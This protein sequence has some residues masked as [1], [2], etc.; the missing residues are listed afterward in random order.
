MTTIINTPPTTNVTHE[1]A[2]SGLGVLL[3]VIIGIIAI[4]LFFVYA[5]PQARINTTP[6]TNN[7]DFNVTVPTPAPIAPITNTN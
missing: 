3:G 7:V 1:N 4:V 6:E 2:D 5:F